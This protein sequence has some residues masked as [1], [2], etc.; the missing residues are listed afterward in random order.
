MAT[1]W[2]AM[3]A[4]AVPAGLWAAAAGQRRLRLSRAKHP[5]LQGHVRLARR[6]SRLLP[7]YTYDESRFFAS[8]GA[9]ADV[10]AARREGFARLAALLEGRAPQSLATVDRLEPMISDLQF[11]RAYQVPFQYA[12]YLRHHLRI[13]RVLDASCGV[14]VE[15]LD[16]NRAYDLTGSYGVNVFGYEFYK[17]CIDEGIARTR[18][19]GPVLGAYHPVV[20]RNVQRLREISGLDEVSFHMSGTEAVMQAVRLA[21]YHTGRSHVVQFAGAYHGWWDGVQPGVGNP[22]S[23]GDVYVLREMS[24]RTLRVLETRRDIACVLIN[25]IQALHPNASAPGDGTL[26]AGG[27]RAGLHRDSYESWL[28][29]LRAVCTRR[30]MS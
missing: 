23:V 18:T 7:G 27:R 14:F 29:D 20:E 15:D 9:P 6:L 26:I 10:V 25:P 17:R 24:E 30:G 5:S 11:T 21:R 22:R 3:A 19:L 2:A 1:E 13:G 8:D 4:M 16:G 12:R 28:A